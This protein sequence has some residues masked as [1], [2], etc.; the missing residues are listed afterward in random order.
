[1]SQFDTAPGPD[2][3]AA[4]PAATIT[5]AEQQAKDFID[6]F[7]VLVAK[8]PKVDLPHPLTVPLARRHRNVPSSYAKAVAGMV[9]LSPD[10]Q[11]ITQYRLDE[12]KSD[13]QQID[14]WTVIDQ[15]ITSFQKAIR[16]FVALKK[17]KTNTAAIQMQTFANA[18]SQ[19]P[20]YAHVLPLVETM[21]EARRSKKSKAKPQPQLP[22]NPT[23]QNGGPILT[24]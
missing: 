22:G 11:A 19:D 13:Q 15:E 7:R 17:A 1:M 16:F 14:A 24:K 5:A 8:L 18:L 4:E 9:A 10:L 12:N 2:T 6:G 3:S 20:A 21:K 23:P